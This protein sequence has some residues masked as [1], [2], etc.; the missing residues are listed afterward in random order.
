M[1][2]LFKAKILPLW[3]RITS[4]RHQPHDSLNPAS[5]PLSTERS[6]SKE[7]RQALEEAGFP[8][9]WVRRLATKQGWFY[10]I[11]LTAPVG[12]EHLK[13]AGR[14]VERVLGAGASFDIN[15]RGA[16]RHDTSV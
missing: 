13:E 4:M 7:V 5:S 2:N 16:T 8:V 9:F 15:D 1:E 12:W 6:R 14:L 3:D 11:K 10:R